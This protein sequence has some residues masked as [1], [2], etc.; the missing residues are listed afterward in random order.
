M[1]TFLVIAAVILGILGIIGSIVPAL[2]GPSLSWLGML[3][4]F[5]RGSAFNFN[6]SAMS[7]STLLIWLIVT[8]L[9]TILDYTMPGWITKATG[10]SKYAAIGAT[11]GLLAGMFLSLMGAVLGMVIGAFV[12]ELIF[13]GK[14]AGASFKS[15]AGAFLG[16]LCSSGIK[17]IVSCIMFIRIGT[18]II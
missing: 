6:T 3:L 11:I 12:A 15:A 18:Y 10:G 14:S 17:L 16:F 13:A 8:I 1:S 7:L 2:P 5:I 4:M 9:V